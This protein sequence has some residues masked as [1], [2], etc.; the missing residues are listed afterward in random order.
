MAMIWSKKPKDP[1]YVDLLRPLLRTGRGFYVLCSALLIVILWFLY[2]WYIQLTQGLG[3]TGMRTPVGA[4]WG[5]YITN[6][7]FFVGIAHGGIAIAAAIKLLKLTKYNPVARM[8]EVLTVVSLMMAGLTIVIDL[9]RP[10]RV[11]LLLTNWT[12]RVQSSPLSWD[13]TVVIMYFTLSTS[14]LWLTLRKD[15]HLSIGRFP[16]LAWIYRILLIGY[17]PDEEHKIDRMTWWLSMAV[18]FLVVM[19]SGGVVPWIFGLLVSR[20]GWYGALASP[21][22]LTAAITSAIAAVIVIAAVLRRLFAWKD[23]IKDDIFRGL[24]AFL[25]VITLLYIYLTFV[26]QVTMRYAPAIFDL[27]VSDI[28][29]TGEFAPIFWPMLIVGLLIPALMLI[30]Q[31]IFPKWRSVSRTAFFAAIICAAFWIKRFLI[32]VPSL[33]RPML[34][35]PEGAYSPSWVEWS[36]LAG[37]FAIAILLFALFLKIFPIVE[38]NEP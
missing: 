23:Q 34:P 9:G 13:I 12:E 1:E 29:I 8:G 27:L 16:R 11:V 33:F 26:E 22:F 37:I 24:G 15:L 25:G 30:G 19:L 21:Y 38:L 4:P 32:V 6:F 20:P 3:V 31:A 2:A 5:L 7:V 36:I 17:N 18:V 14:F 10:D 28:L 35:F